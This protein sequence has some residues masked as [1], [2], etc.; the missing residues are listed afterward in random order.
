MDLKPLE[1]FS[2]RGPL[3]REY[4]LKKGLDCPAVYGDPA[5]LCPL[6]YSPVMK[7][8][9]KIG[10][11][12]HHNDCIEK[13][14]KILSEYSKEDVC[15]ISLDSYDNWKNFIDA[16]CSCDFILSSS[17]HGVIIADAYSVPNIWCEFTYHVEDNG[18]KF[19]DYYLSVGKDFIEP[20]LNIDHYISIDLL[21]EYRKVWTRNEINLDAIISACPFR[22]KN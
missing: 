1:I 18:L 9:Y 15:L 4:F 13:N 17:L 22:K 10:I 16:V 11:I 6:F 3:T 7:K 20:V 19:R 21:L 2:V 14:Y 12:L 8:K 5:L